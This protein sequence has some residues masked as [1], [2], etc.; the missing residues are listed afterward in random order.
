[1]R[2]AIA[3]PETTRLLLEAVRSLNG[4]SE[5]LNVAKVVISGNGKTPID[6][7]PMKSK[8]TSDAIVRA[9]IA[10]LVQKYCFE[11]TRQGVSSHFRQGVYDVSGREILVIE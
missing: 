7:L 2:A 5:K 1:M 4:T 3:I 10:D 11:C 6:Y 9:G 8:F